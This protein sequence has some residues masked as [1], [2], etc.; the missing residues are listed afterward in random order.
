MNLYSQLW[1]INL[2]IVKT[3][4]TGAMNSASKMIS[5]NPQE[6]VHLFCQAA[7]YFRYISNELMPDSPKSKKSPPECLDAFSTVM[8]TFSLA[9]AQ[10]AVSWSAK[11]RGTSPSVTLKLFCAAKD[12]YAKLESNIHEFEKRVAENMQKFVRSRSLY[13][14]SHVYIMYA[15][16]CTA[17]EYA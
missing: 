7:G 11:S 8:E 6:S 9:L 1:Y 14:Q 16:I 3:I 15:E 10:E 4:G 17:S 13:I 5:T 12:L 2:F